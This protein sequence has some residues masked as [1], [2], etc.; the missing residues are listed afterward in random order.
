MRHFLNDKKIILL[1]IIFFLLMPSCSD[2]DWKFVAPMPNKGRYGHDATLGPDGRIYVMGGMVFDILEN[3]K[4]GAKIYDGMYSCLVY[5]IKKDKWEFIEPVPGNIRSGSYKIYDEQKGFWR[6]VRP[7]KHNIE[8]YYEG[9]FPEL[10]HEKPWKLYPDPIPPE[11]LR[12]THVE[13]RGDGVAIVTG[14]DKIIY[15]IGGDDLGGGIGEDIVLPYDPIKKKWPDSEV[16]KIIFPSAPNESAYTTKTIFKTNIPPMHE[17][18][19]DHEAVVTSDGK[20]YVMG[21]RRMIKQLD[22]MGMLTSTGVREVSDTLECY[23]PK[24]NKWEY[25]KSMSLK[26][27]LFAAVVGRDDRIYTFGG[28]DF[29]SRQDRKTYNIAEVY[30]P[31]TDKWASLRPL[32]E[33]RDG[34]AG[35]LGSDGKIYILGGASDFNGPPLKSVFIY[36]PAMDKWEKGPDMNLPRHTL[37][38]VA[39]PDGKI[40]AIGGTDVGAYD[41]K[42]N[43]NV[44]LPQ[45]ADFYT[46]KAQDTVE[47]LDIFK[48]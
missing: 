20:I 39:T 21:G 46:G 38:A 1:L 31:K 12:K 41:T 16:K 32:P 25:K 18:R 47:V 48:K 5:D 40:Y 4:M 9:Y 33:P 44:F 13:R 26:R 19:I 34:I 30:D 37:A 10:D 3:K 11:K 17:R 2:A 36:D 43:F 45:K 14:K 22:T 6:T 8:N 24:T 15:W 35:V 29:I 28:T 42:K 7:A 27:F 23:D